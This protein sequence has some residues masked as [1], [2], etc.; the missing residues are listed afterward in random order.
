MSQLKDMLN[1]LNEDAIDYETGKKVNFDFVKEA[2][3]IV[4]KVLK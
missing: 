1:K 3:K 4:I 2:K